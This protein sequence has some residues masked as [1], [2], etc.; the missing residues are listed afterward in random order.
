[1]KKSGIF[2]IGLVLIGALTAACVRRCPVSGTGTAEGLEANLRGKTVYARV[3]EGCWQ[4]EGDRLWEMLDLEKTKGQPI[5][6]AGLVLQLAECYLLEFYPGGQ[7]VAYDG[8]A[9]SMEQNYQT[10][11]VPEETEELLT[12]WVLENGTQLRDSAASFRR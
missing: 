2:I 1:M 8:Y 9:S 4:V 3:E 7:A 6:E 11:Q 10:Y 12:A 5:G